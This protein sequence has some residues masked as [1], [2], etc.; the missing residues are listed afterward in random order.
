MQPFDRPF[1]QGETTEK[2]DYT[3]L[4]NKQVDRIN[5]IGTTGNIQ[6]FIN[7]VEILETMLEAY[8]D[9]SFDTGIVKKEK[10]MT[11][12]YDSYPPMK[13]AG[14]LTQLEYTFAMLKYKECVKL[15]GRKGLIPAKKLVIKDTD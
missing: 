6:A 3:Y 9:S 10:Q 11:S 5:F 12:R 7:A 14:I 4:L 1:E 15:M 8:K 13:R 2:T